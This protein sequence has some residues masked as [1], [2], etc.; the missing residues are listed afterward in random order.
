MSLF[1]NQGIGNCSESSRLVSSLA[2]IVRIHAEVSLWFAIVVA[3]VRGVLG[4][5]TPADHEVGGDTR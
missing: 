3:G 2:T 4:P 5:F 1:H